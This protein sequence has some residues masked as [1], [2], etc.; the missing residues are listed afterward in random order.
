MALR[1]AWGEAAPGLGSCAALKSATASRWQMV[2]PKIATDAAPS[3]KKRRSAPKM[4]KT[5]VPGFRP[6]YRLGS[7]A[8]PFNC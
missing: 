5:L 3:N 2:C 4:T 6:K 7:V 1:R 8:G